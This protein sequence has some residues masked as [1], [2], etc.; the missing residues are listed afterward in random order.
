MC[1]SRDSAVALQPTD[2]Y[3]KDFFDAPSKAVRPAKRKAPTSPSAPTRS[4]KVHFNEQVKVKEIRNKGKGRSLS[5]V[6][7]WTGEDAS[8]DDE[9]EDSPGEGS[10]LE[11]GAESEE[12]ES[13]G[14]FG[15]ESTGDDIDQ[16]RE[17]IERLK[18]DLFA[19]YDDQDHAPKAGQ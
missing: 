14:E 4:S 13:D 19:D 2:T 8:E 7:L 9:D 6:D 16:G 11:E 3:Y 5:S 18:D 1:V 17:A 12:I 15:S 10:Y